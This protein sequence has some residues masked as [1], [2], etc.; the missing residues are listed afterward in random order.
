MKKEK[1]TVVEHEAAKNEVRDTEKRPKPRK[2]KVTIACECR[3][4]P[5][6][7]GGYYWEHVF[8][9]APSRMNRKNIHEAMKITGYKLIRLSGLEA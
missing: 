9:F 3:K 8:R 5:V 6:A 4:V 1:S 2:S 7:G